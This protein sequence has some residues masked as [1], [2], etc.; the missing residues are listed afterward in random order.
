MCGAGG[1]GIRSLGPRSRAGVVGLLALVRQRS[2]WPA[3]SAATANGADERI[4][5]P[6]A[7]GG[8]GRNGTIETVEDRFAERCRISQI[9]PPNMLFVSPEFQPPRV[10][11]TEGLQLAVLSPAFAEADFNAVSASAQN[12][13]NVFGLQN[14]WPNANISFEENRIDL[15]RHGDEFNRRVAF[16]YALL[17]PSGTQYLGCL[18]VMP[19]KSKLAVDYRKHKYQAQA[20]V[21]LSVL[22]PEHSVDHVVAVLARW[23]RD[24]WPFGAVAFPGRIQSWAEWEALAHTSP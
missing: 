2:G 23:L 22:A 10:Y 9:A 4:P 19:I 13:R 12:I 18:Y 6:P 21:W 3:C 11:K 1:P 17:D 15:A 8:V 14:D 5:D 24:D 16:A 7:D 20:F